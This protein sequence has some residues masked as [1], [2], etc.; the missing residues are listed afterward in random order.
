[1][2]FAAL[3]IICCL[4]SVGA[5]AHPFHASL[6][7]IEY[8]VE[9]EL[10]EIAVRLDITDLERALSHYSDR[11][12]VITEKTQHDE[13]L[14]SYLQAHFQMTGHGVDGTSELVLQWIGKQL[15]ISNL[16]I[17]VAAPSKNIGKLRLN[18]R[19]LHDTV[20]DQVNTVVLLEHG[21]RRSHHLNAEQ[22]VLT[23]EPVINHD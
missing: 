3:S 4:I 2:R 12:I 10:L 6:T 14:R 7:E 1:M 19:L 21:A 22:T 11:A 18:N 9:A 17:Y 23:W 15:E 20:A 16:W 13:L 8:N 5:E